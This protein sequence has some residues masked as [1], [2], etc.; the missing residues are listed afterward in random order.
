MGIQ[1]RTWIW[2]I[3]MAIL[4]TSGL[5]QAHRPTGNMNVI[6]GCWRTD[7]N[8]RRNR[9]QLATCSVGYAGKMTNNV[10]RGT[11]NYVV[12]DPGDDP[13]NPKPGTL[14]FGMTSVKGKVWITF[15]RDMNIKL[16]KPLLV[17]SFT[18]LDGRGANV[19]I[20]SGACLLLQEVFT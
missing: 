20:T 14:R 19:H 3:S 1:G 11:V 2:A 12:T 9:H 4:F 8:W 15:Q 5:V 18:A 10:G 17:G 16:A 6:D 7:P 13:L